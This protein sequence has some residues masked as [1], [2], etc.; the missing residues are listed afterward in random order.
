MNTLDKLITAWRAYEKSDNSNRV[1]TMR[2]FFNIAF[3]DEVKVPQTGPELGLLIF[4]P[5]LD[6]A[7]QEPHV[8]AL[9]GIRRIVRFRSDLI[10]QNFP[11]FLLWMEKYNHNLK[12]AV[13]PSTK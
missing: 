11:D 9:W 10:K 12:T 5:R 6:I 7:K 1:A 8:V 2:D 4:D 3:S 13:P